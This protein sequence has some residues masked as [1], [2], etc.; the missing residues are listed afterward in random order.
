M[1]LWQ[2]A[3]AAAPAGLG[4]DVQAVL[5]ELVACIGEP[6][7]GERALEQLNRVMAVG[8]WSVYRVFDDQPPALHASASHGLPDTTRQCFSLYRAGLYRADQTLALARSQLQPGQPVMT[9][10]SADEIPGLHREQIYRRHGVRERLSLLSADDGRGLLTLNLYR[11]EQQRRFADVEVDALRTVARVL[12]A[13]V[14]KHLLLGAAPSALPGAAAA[15]AWLAPLTPRERQ[16]CE[17]LL[18]GL[19]HDGIAA[20]LGLSVTTV[21]TYRNRAFARLGIHH[22]SELF[23]LGRRAGLA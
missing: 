18:Q 4:G 22:R 15:N 7:F 14:R 6:A 17:R 23:G 21:K 16:V 9:H 10:W 3:P 12:L 2:V 5:G 13:C 8:S 11:H 20:D 1:Q 19:S